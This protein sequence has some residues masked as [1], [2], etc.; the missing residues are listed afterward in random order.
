MSKEES[1]CKKYNLTL[2]EV[3]EFRR[4]PNIREVVAEIMESEGLEFNEIQSPENIKRITEI[5]FE[6][7]K[8]GKESDINDQG[9]Q[10]CQTCKK[11]TWHTPKLGLVFNGKR[12]C[13]TCRTSNYFEK[14]IT[15]D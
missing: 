3:D 12:L 1:L 5:W 7:I 15:I 2:S 11:E 14:K 8:N 4:D 13:Q 9:I 10:Y 6:V